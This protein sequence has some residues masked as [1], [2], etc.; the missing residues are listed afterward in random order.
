MKRIHDNI[1]WLVAVALLWLALPAKCEV[2]DTVTFDFSGLVLEDVTAG[3]ETFLLPSLPDCDVI[4][5]TGAPML[6]VKYVRLSVP[7]NATNISVSS[8]ASGSSTVLSQRIYPAPVPIATDDSVTGQPD[9]VIDSAIYMTSSFW[10]PE[11]VELVGDGFYMGDNHI[12][13]V[14]VYPTRYNPV[15]SR[16]RKMSTVRFAVNYDL[17]D[18]PANMLVRRGGDLRHQEQLSVKAMVDNPGQVETFAMQPAQIQHLPVYGLLPDS[19]QTD[20]TSNY[21]GGDQEIW[22]DRAR[23][24]IVTTREL[25]PAFKRLAALKR[26]KGYSVQIKCIEDILA[27]PRVQL[28]DR[29]KVEGGGYSCINDDAGKLRQYLKLAYTYDNTQFVL[30]G[31][32]DVPYRYGWHS[33]YFSNAGVIDIPTDQYYVDLTSNWNPHNNATAPFGLAHYTY[34]LNPELWVGRLLGDSIKWIN[35]YS[36][37]LLRYEL[38]PGKGDRSYLKR[39][40]SFEQ[41]ELKNESD[42]IINNL[43]NVFIQKTV[44]R[45]DSI[46]YNTGGE[47]ISEINE[48]GYGFIGIFAHGSPNGVVAC[49]YS[50]PKSAIK[51]IHLQNKV[52]HPEQWE[53]ASLNGFDNL[54][55]TYSPSILYTVSCTTMPFDIYSPS[56]YT[57]DVEMN[58]GE[59]FTLG[60]GYGG[61]AY[62]GNTRQGG[63]KISSY[64]GYH[65]AKQIKNGVFHLGQAEAES[66]KTFNRKYF[67]MV[68]N[69][70]GDPETEIWTDEPQCYSTATVTRGTDYIS[71]TGLDVGDY[72]FVGISD[73]NVQ[74]M[75]S[76]LTSNIT[77]TNVNPNSTVMI[78]RHNYLPYIAPLYLQNE[79]V[80]RSQ[81]VIANDVYA[82]RSV[83]PNRTDGDL[84][85]ASGSEYEIES[86][87]RVLLAPGFKVEKGALFSVTR[88]DY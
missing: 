87:G 46:N 47:F 23:Y 41:L 48:T 4:D 81:Y 42:T 27:D 68:H 85:I 56:Y 61:I 64:L 29:C 67:A 24:L 60:K 66:K 32:K 59:S 34:D 40:I 30:L 22:G 1:R 2:R 70:L 74:L 72:T 69:L 45:E 3:G 12:V 35:N 5:Q 37:K 26:Q 78:Y 53:N 14:A 77:L 63:I 28:G 18:T 8:S 25:A 6:P 10:P 39:A 33:T 76:T 71:L 15:T 13:T 88:S 73:G 11:A 84:T 20:T 79:H 54:T 9:M 52:P 80:E 21:Y 50:S 65:F 7:Y 31:G 51:A 82:G 17:G 58:M 49:K 86:K 83:D 44:M 75:D 19:A 62:L 16:L 38:N 55:N 57:Y 36:D 43:N